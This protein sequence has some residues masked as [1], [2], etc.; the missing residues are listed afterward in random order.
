MAGTLLGLLILLAL[1]IALLGGGEHGPWRH[2]TIAND[3]GASDDPLDGSTRP[4]CRAQPLD[5]GGGSGAALTCDDAQGTGEIAQRFT[6]QD[7]GHGGLDVAWELRS[8][9][10]TVSVVDDDGTTVVSRTY[11]GQGSDTAGF[12][13]GQAGSW[14]VSAERSAGFEGT[15]NV[16]TFCAANAG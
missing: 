8:G 7:P 11:A 15:F 3:P 16:Q 6:C 12:S 2:T 5:H 1:G 14:E 4:P 10:V 9:A 13:Q